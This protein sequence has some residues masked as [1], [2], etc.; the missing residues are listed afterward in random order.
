MSRDVPLLRAKI[1]MIGAP[2]V[3]KTSLVSRYVHSVFSDEYHSTLGVK[4][5]RKTVEL[6]N[7]KVAM[8]LWDLHG[9][10]EGLDIP[11]SYLR[12]VTAGIAVTDG[13]R[14][15]TASKAAELRD[16][17]LA[18][19]P[20]AR[21]HAV[22]NKSDLDVDWGAVEST[23]TGLG[24]QFVARTSAKDGSGVEDVF[25]TLAQEIASSVS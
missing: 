20:N 13:S 17:L 15:E 10:T 1:V 16:R 11:A 5:D 7:A 19:S 24:L 4:V 8:L 9:E 22:V 25:D 6:E 3:G 23:G 21:V 12:G 18:A 14:I 2:G